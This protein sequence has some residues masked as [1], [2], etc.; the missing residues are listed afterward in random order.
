MKIYDSIVIGAGQSGLAASYY[1]KKSGLNFLVL[2]ASK[3]TAG[4]WPKYYDSLTLFSPAKYSS[5]PGY[6]FPG[7][8][9]HYPTKEE[10]IS[11]LLDYANHFK[12]NIHT[13]NIV[14]DVLKKEDV[15][16][17]ITKDGSE[18]KSKT[19]ISATGA[20]NYPFIPEIEGIDIFRGKKVHSSQYRNVTDFKNQRIIVVGGGNS[21]V[22]IAY[23]LS[24]VSNVTIASRNPIAFVP[25]K[26]LGKDVHF[27]FKVFGVDWLPLKKFLSNNTSVLDSGI[28]KQA[29]LNK[30]PEHKMMFKSFT[31]NGVVWGDGTKENIDTVVFATGYRPN[32]L[33]LDSLTNASKKG[34]PI[35]VKG[36][37]QTIP[38][39]YFIGLEWQRS[40][41]SA[42]LRGVGTDAKYIVNN[43]KHRIL[44]EY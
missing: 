35:Q 6:P 27:W 10:V 14:S 24:K 9:D 42:T 34:I 40:F 17:I 4:S 21:A 1:L 22:Q 38:G 41:S 18:F 11:Y 37:S 23:E 15:F 33:Y 16:S 13:E 39:L 28:Y 8:P 12:F 30:R 20:F 32:V 7:D 19:V 26:I 44:N 43:L 29:I 25:Q 5:L 2:E 3:T 31:K 36:I